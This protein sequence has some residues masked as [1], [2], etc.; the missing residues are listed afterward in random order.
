MC[1]RG[2]ASSVE[3]FTSEHADRFGVLNRV[4]KLRPTLHKFQSPWRSCRTGVARDVF[5]AVADTSWARVDTSSMTWGDALPSLH[6]EVV[7]VDLPGAP[8]EEPMSFRRE[9]STQRE[10][11]W[12]TE[13]DLSRAQA[14]QSSDSRRCPTRVNPLVVADPQY[15]I[16]PLVNTIKGRSSRLHRGEFCV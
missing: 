6:G 10:N 7:D 5:V 3:A 9:S 13:T 4:L 12:I 11:K 2:R 15:G 8:A 14:R 1:D 16:H